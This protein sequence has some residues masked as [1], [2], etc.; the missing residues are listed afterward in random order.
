M[1]EDSIALRTVARAEAQQRA[2]EE[3][4]GEW[5]HP[6]TREQAAYPLPGL[7]A[8]KYWA[9]VKRV[10]QVFGDRHFFCGCPQPE[11]SSRA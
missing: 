8:R 11:L 3:L 7:R 2:A 4:A 9:P 5:R 1:A 6:Y 10:D